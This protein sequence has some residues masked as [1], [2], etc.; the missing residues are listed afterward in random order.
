MLRDLSRAQ[1]AL[2]AQGF[3]L[4]QAPVWLPAVRN[5]PS[6]PQTYAE[7]LQHHGYL[8]GDGVLGLARA[9]R[10]LFDLLRPDLL[11]LDYAP[12][13]LLA[14]RGLPVARATI[15]SSFYLPPQCDPI[16][17]FRATDAQRV[18]RAEAKV[19]EVANH[20]MA[21][22]GVP[23]VGSLAEL[24][25][26]DEDFLATVP[27]LD[28]YPRRPG[29]RYW[30]LLSDGTGGAAPEWA[31]GAGL[32]VFAYLKPN[33]PHLDAVLA[34]LADHGAD[35]SIFAPDLS[36]RTLSRYRGEHMR[37]SRVPLNVARASQECD[38]AI[39][40][41]GHD[42]MVA[43]LLHGKPVFLIPLQVEQALTAQQAAAAGLGVAVYHRDGAESVRQKLS[44][45]LDDPAYRERARGFAAAHA[46]AL[47]PQSLQRC[48]TRCEELLAQCKPKN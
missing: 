36:P 2:G 48:I 31:E 16:P 11:L 46:A 34:T 37:F 10:G 28:L 23:R 35:C 15:G 12:T 33:Y 6:P 30:G 17:A 47:P 19:V 22:L 40:H 29:A 24:L 27:E 8:D 32:R 42:T 20:A 41:A 4:Y 1:A 45:L 44:Q 21:G 14:S 5:A 9:W 3:A 43:P 38:I 39:C 7:I 25:R 26:C 18:R 13:A